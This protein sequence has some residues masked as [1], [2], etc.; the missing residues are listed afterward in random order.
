MKCQIWW[1]WR[2]WHWL[3]MNQHECLKRACRAGHNRQLNFALSA[4]KRET[5]LAIPRPYIFPFPFSWL[6]DNWRRVECTKTDAIPSNVWGVFGKSFLHCS[7]Q[8]LWG[9]GGHGNSYREKRKVPARQI[10]ACVIWFIT[11]SRKEIGLAA[12][13]YQ[14][15]SPTDCA[16]E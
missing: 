9:L 1:H 8:R 2:C 10:N 14:I 6:H 16:T 11:P 5:Q 12:A 4:R 3:S 13:T 7:L 15:L